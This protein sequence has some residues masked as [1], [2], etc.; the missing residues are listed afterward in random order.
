[1]FSNSN[2]V[3]GNQIAEATTGPPNEERI[4]RNEPDSRTLLLRALGPKT[5]TSPMAPPPE[6]PA[7]SFAVDPTKPASDGVSHILGSAQSYNERYLSPQQI[8][9]ALRPK[10][11]IQNVTRTVSTEP[12]QARRS[13]GLMNSLEALRQWRTN[14]EQEFFHR[15]QYYSIPQ[16]H[17]GY[18]DSE[19]DIRGS[20]GNGI[21]YRNQRRE[22]EPPH[23]YEDAGTAQE[24]PYVRRLDHKKS[25][26]LTDV[27]I[28]PPGLPR[29]SDDHVTTRYIDRDFMDSSPMHT[30]YS[31]EETE[32]SNGD[33]GAQDG[34][35]L[36][37]DKAPSSAEAPKGCIANEPDVHENIN[38]GALPEVPSPTPSLLSKTYHRTLTILSR[39]GL[40]ENDTRPG[41][42]RIRWKNSRGKW[43]YDDYVEHVPGALE[44]MK[45]F[46]RSSAYV[47]AAA[48][49]GGNQ[50]APASFT[51]SDNSTSSASQKQYTPL[52]E[53]ADQSKGS[54]IL[55]TN[56]SQTDVEL[57]EMISH[58]PLL[59]SCLE[60]G[61]YAVKLRQEYI[62]GVADDLQLFHTLR[63]IYHE[64]RGRRRPIWSLKT[65]HS[66]HF[67]KVN[68]P[69]LTLH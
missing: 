8:D 60:N 16:L 14:K 49:D 21:L 12:R 34:L 61:K 18:E 46:L 23:R 66:I 2:D 42:K 9:P 67:M 38:A 45:A 39:I 47:A 24:G 27:M 26:R 56:D 58:P 31:A 25:N 68:I 36:L 40:R 41:H 4:F 48:M 35:R 69:A 19:D 28:E 57:G 10:D 15:Q 22:E 51:P 64:H 6:R 33:I 20:E 53:I 17:F 43:L 65:L 30:S 29:P 37:E 59:L 62:V 7:S 5:P 63:R 54:E 13:Y 1:M 3:S 50:D 55:H 52:S 44:D 11:S 32:D